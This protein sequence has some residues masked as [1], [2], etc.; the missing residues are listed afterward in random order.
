MPPSSQNFQFEKQNVDSSVWD[1]SVKGVRVFHG[2]TVLSLQF[3]ILITFNIQQIFRECARVHNTWYSFL[4]GLA[5]D[6]IL[7]CVWNLS[8]PGG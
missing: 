2:I 7:Q 6:Y 4:S 3:P 1:L 8:K 5:G